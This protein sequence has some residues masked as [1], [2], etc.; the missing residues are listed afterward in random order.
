MQAFQEL[1]GINKPGLSSCV[2]SLSP[3]LLHVLLCPCVTPRCMNRFSAH[4]S[5]KRQCYVD[6]A[7]RTGVVSAV[8][9]DINTRIE[10]EMW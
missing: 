8:Q 4:W 6:A 7:T 2:A 1:E 10:D 3:V 9:S 5:Y